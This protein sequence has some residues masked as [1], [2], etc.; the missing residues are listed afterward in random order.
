V[1]GEFNTFSINGYGLSGRV[2]FLPESDVWQPASYRDDMRISKIL[3]FGDRYR[4]YL[5][6]EIFNL[7]NSWSPTSMNTEAFT[8]SASTK[9]CGSAAVTPCL[10]PVV[11]LGTG[12]G[13]ALN[14]DGTEARRLQVSARFT[15]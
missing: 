4:L 9:T 8:E 11:N 3:P 2:P 12:F 10:Q 6:F 5:N 7:S 13:D 14:P 1:T 15:F